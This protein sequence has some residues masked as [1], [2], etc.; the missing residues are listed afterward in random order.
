MI[1]ILFLVMLVMILLSPREK[2]APLLVSLDL[3]S[4]ER[5][6]ISHTM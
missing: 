1:V 2:K 6:G 3:L 4:L 5:S